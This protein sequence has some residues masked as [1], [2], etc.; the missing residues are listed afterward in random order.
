M[1]HLIEFTE[2]WFAEVQTSPGRLR[3][4][5]F[6]RG[7][8]CVAEVSPDGERASGESA[9]LKLH[10]GTVAIHIPFTRFSQ[11][12]LLPRAA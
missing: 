7:T 6:Q 3:Q 8:K 10:D 1:A 2:D 4:V 9:N 12:A 11:T 5:E